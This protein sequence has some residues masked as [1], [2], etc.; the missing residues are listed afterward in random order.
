M[1]DYNLLE[2]FSWLCMLKAT[3]SILVNC[4]ILISLTEYCMN[5]ELPKE[6]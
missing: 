5:S 6:F 1:P 4:I 3:K 2:G